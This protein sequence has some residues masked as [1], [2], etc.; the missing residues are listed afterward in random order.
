VSTDVFTT[1]AEAHAGDSD[2]LVVVEPL[3]QLL[4]AHGIPEPFTVE[5]I[6]H[7]L[8]NAT[9][10]LLFGDGRRLVLRRPPR[11]PLPPSAHDVLREARVLRA[12]SSTPVP[13]P[14]VLISCENTAVIGAPFYVMEHCD[15]RAPVL[16]L[17][18]ALQSPRERRRFGEALVDALVAIHSVDLDAVGL[19]IGR[20]SG[21]LERQIELHLALWESSQAR[22]LT[23]VD[24]LG[25]WLCESIPAGGEVTLIHGDFHP[26]NVLV[27]ETAP[28]RITAVLDW[29]LATRGD[30]LTDLGYLCALWREPGEPIDQ[31]LERG[32]VTRGEGSLTRRDLRERYAERSGHGIGEIGWYEVLARWRAII[33]MEANFR[34]T[35]RAD[36]G[37]RSRVTSAEYLSRLALAATARAAA[38]EEDR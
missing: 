19:S 34:R 14:R 24:R 31:P 2:P 5:A 30:P 3:S 35:A 32:P 10:R 33:F 8:S 36:P 18:H 11:G 22:E 17:P 26:A 12:L 21:H 15:G 4:A 23:E 6:D 25:A 27:S 1:W 29:E 38:Y 9:F 16:G 28:A 37:A 7:G 13:V 20:G